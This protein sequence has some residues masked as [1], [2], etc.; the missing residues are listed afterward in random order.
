[1]NLIKLDIRFLHA[2]AQERRHGDGTRSA[3]LLQAVVEMARA[4]H[5]RTLC[6]GVE[7]REQLELLRQVGCRG[8]QGYFLGRPAPLEQIQVE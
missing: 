5:L 7:T 3:A 1:M 8:A 2:Y 6:E 4:L